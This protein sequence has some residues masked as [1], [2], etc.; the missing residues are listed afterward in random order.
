MLTCSSK[1]H[2]RPLEEPGRLSR[3][4]TAA[5]GAD[6]CSGTSLGAARVSVSCVWG[7]AA[8]SNSSAAGGAAARLSMSSC[9]RSQLLSVA[10]SGRRRAAAACAIKPPSEPAARVGFGPAVP[11]VARGG[12]GSLWPP[13][14]PGWLAGGTMLPAGLY[15][16]A[17]FG[18]SLADAFCSG[19]GRAAGAAAADDAFS[20]ARPGERTLEPRHVPASA[21]QAIQWSCHSPARA[22]CQSGI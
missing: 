4:S 7:P 14:T 20:S 9:T 13:Q 6:A 19:R 11:C 18:V 15:S 1:P 2:R 3:P 5:G 17:S 12:L 22:A 21:G 10:E 8:A 16:P